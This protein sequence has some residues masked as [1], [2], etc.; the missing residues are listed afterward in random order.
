MIN[1]YAQD[2]SGGQIE[3]A[4]VFMAWNFSKP[5]YRRD[6]IRDLFEKS[7]LPSKYLGTN[8][9]EEIFKRA[10]NKGKTRTAD[11]HKIKV[12][13]IRKK[14]QTT[15]YQYFVAR[16][17]GDDLVFDLL[18][19]VFYDN[20]TDLVMC[21]NSD[22]EA[23][24]K[25]EMAFESE[26][27]TNN[28]MHRFC[29]SLFTKAKI[30]PVRANGG[31]YFVPV[32]YIEQVDRFKVFYDQVEDPASF[33]Y[34]EVP[35]TVKARKTIEYAYKDVLEQKNKEAGEEFLALMNAG[36]GMSK[37]IYENRIEEF[38]KRLGDLKIYKEV[39][40]SNMEQSEA[41]IKFFK[42][43]THYMRM[44]NNVHPLF[45]LYGDE[46]FTNKELA[47]VIVRWNDVIE[48]KFEVLDMDNVFNYVDLCNG[49]E[50]E[51]YAEGAI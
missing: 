8:S 22:V 32:H 44:T 24:I 25:K 50:I 14:G 4:G 6:V 28:D 9:K 19:K 38:E 37:T 33:T 34:S 13:E 17:E 3:L 26:H 2:S 5:Y 51:P 35:A 45:K 48:K 41:S 16:T 31:V 36:E 7:G 10:V 1:K 43:C 47:D 23:M 40:Q 29:K 12:E 20:R 21:T 39:T 49:I 18:D 46:R 27:Y 42:E 15:I 30:I 11:G